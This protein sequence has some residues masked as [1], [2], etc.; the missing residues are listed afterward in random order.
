MAGRLR[1]DPIPTAT[2]QPGKTG[3]IVGAVA[4]GLPALLQI[5]ALLYALIH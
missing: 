3:R 4:V 5:G 2:F 1:I